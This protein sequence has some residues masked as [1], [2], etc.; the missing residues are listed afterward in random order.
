MISGKVPSIVVIKLSES[1]SQSSSMMDG[2]SG[3][4]MNTSRLAFTGDY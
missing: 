3:Y 2:V 4:I 1:N